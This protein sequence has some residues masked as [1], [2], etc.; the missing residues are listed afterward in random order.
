MNDPQPKKPKLLDQVRA[1]ARKRHLA[2]STENQYVRWIRR[3]ILFHKKQHPKE[4][5]REHVERFL[6]HLAVEDNVASST[7]NQALAALLFLY[8]EVLELDFGWL[9]NVT[10][11][12][13][14]KQLPVVLTSDEVAAL[15]ENLDGL[16]HLLASLLYGSGLR[17][18]ECLRLRI[19]DVNLERLELTVRDGKGQKDRITILA[20]TVVPAIIAHIEKTRQEFER[21]KRQGFVGVYLPHALERKYPNA[22]QEWGWQYVFPAPRPSRDPR[23]G[24]IRRHHLSE[25]PLQEAVKRAIR[26]AGINKHASCHT[27][28]HTFATQLLHSGTDIRTVQELLGHKDVRTTQIYTHVIGANR[29]AVRSPIDQIPKRKTREE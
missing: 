7:Q 6:S 17:L 18:K 2:L 12:N 23:T 29:N 14:P 22:S 5:N 8:R 4:L 21:D 9:Q 10:R 13:R 27:L 1:Q 16:P 15:F 24:I 28:R 20:R 3:F 26:L 19:K 25:R 11:A